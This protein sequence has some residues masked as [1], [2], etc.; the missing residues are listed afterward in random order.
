MYVDGKWVDAEG[1]A[2]YALPNPA[3]EETI[4]TAPDASRRDMKRAIEAARRAFDSGPWRKTTP[5]DRARILVAL[6]DG[7][8][9]R[10]EE[11]RKLLVSAHACE[12]ITH[13]VNLDIAI[14]QLRNYAE[15]T[16]V[17]PFEQHLASIA[18][19]NPQGGEML[20]GSMV[21]HQPP[22]D[23]AGARD[24]LHDGGEAVPVRPARR[25]APRRSRGAVRPAA[26]RRQR[27]VR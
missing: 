22:E 26:G 27:R 16:H 14:E 6:A 13:G 9:A 7:V 21:C 11:F 1:G 2:S 8:E 5:A 4:A 15:L 12:S 25:P 18:T 3:T 17:F 24:R 23:R 20:V 10:K 19:A